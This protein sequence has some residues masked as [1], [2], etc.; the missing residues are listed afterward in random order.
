[1][2]TIRLALVT[3]GLALAASS[4]FAR[5]SFSFGINIGGPGYYAPP[6]VRYYP[7]PPPVYYAPPPVYYSPAPRAYYAPAPRAYYYYDNGPRHNH[8]HGGHRDGWRRD[9]WR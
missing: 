3:I 1:M 6:P 5:D 2:K 8:G 9:G 4:A 7:A